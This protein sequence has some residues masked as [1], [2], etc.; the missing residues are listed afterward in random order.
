MGE[1]RRDEAQRTGGA[2]NQT[3]KI[4]GAVS[5]LTKVVIKQ[6]SNDEDPVN[7]PG[8]MISVMAKRSSQN[9]IKNSSVGISGSIDAVIPEG[10]LTGHL[11]EFNETKEDPS[12]DTVLESW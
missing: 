11:T 10:V 8:A 5:T 6:H 1:W 3:E 12:F 7:I 2:K 9:G 4:R